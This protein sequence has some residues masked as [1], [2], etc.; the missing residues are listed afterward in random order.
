MVKMKIY[1]NFY[2]SSEIGTLRVKTNF[3]AP[4]FFLKSITKYKTGLRSREHSKNM[5]VLEGK[6]ISFKTK[7]ILCKKGFV[8]LRTFYIL[9]HC[10]NRKIFKL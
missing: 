10:E 5:F 7:M 8:A 6:G 2:P 9:P 3:T 1:V 4:F